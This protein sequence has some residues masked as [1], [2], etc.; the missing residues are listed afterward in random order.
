MPALKDN[1][2]EQF[3]AWTM[4]PV[5]QREPRT[6]AALAELL[7][8][9]DRTLRDWRD[10]DDFQAEW[11]A[12]FNET[13]GSLDRLKV[14]LDGLYED[15]TDRD[16]TDSDRRQAAKL[17]FEIS[18]QVAPP[19]PEIKSSARAADL[20]DEELTRMLSDAALQE[21]KERGTV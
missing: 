3:L 20:S 10:R 11:R 8:V 2:H 14:L 5:A 15:S 7:G 9:G 17:Y 6:Q 1:R 19:E 18:K 4:T 13:A 21:L 12:R 16:L